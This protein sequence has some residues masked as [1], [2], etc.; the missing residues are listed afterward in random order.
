MNIIF[1]RFKEEDIEV[2]ANTFNFSWTTPEASKILWSK[3]YEEQK[4]HKRTV[5]IIEKDGKPIGY[6]SFL[7]VSE[8]AYFNN[9]NIPEINN[10][11]IAFEEQRKGYGTKLLVYLENLAKEEGFT[12]IGI[13]VGLYR[14]YGHAQ[15]LYCKLGY[16]PDG[17]GITYKYL[18]V[19]PGEQYPV[20][21]DL[22][23]WF[24]KQI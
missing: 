16:T 13:G 23:L 19:I 10:V 17:N 21:D 7:R 11:R 15:K 4:K 5:C 1:R 8:Y 6:G 24:T 12:Q 3:H 22:V 18:P 2:I 9:A 20:D 14:D